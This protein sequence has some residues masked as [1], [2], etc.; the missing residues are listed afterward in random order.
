MFK[1]YLKTAIRNMKLL[2]RL[3][4]TISI[5]M[6]LFSSNVF[7]QSN[8]IENIENGLL[9]DVLIKGRASENMNIIDRMKHHNVPGVSIAVIDN[10]K[11][12]WAKA[13]GVLD[14]ESKNQVNTKTLFQAASISKP[15]ASIAALSLV[16]DG[17][18]KLEEN[19]NHKLTSWKVPDNEFTANHKVTLQGILNHSAGVTVHGFGGYASNEQVPSLLQVLNGEK[20]ANSDPI[21]VDIKPDSL[22]RYSGG[23]YTIM[24]QLLIDLEQKPFHELMEKKILA[25]LKMKNSTYEQPLP[26]KYWDNAARAH[27]TNGDMIAGNWHTYPEMAAAGLWTTPTDLAKFSIEMM[28]SKAGKSNKILSEEMT[29][30]MLTKVIGNNGLGFNLGGKGENFY[31]S[32]GGS[33]EG[34]KCN[35]IAIPGTGQGAVIMTNGDGGGNLASEII[36]AISKEYG[37]EIYKAKEKS[38]VVIDEK[39]YGQYEGKYELMPDFIVQVN[40]GD[41]RL[42]LEIPGEGVSEYYPISENKFFALDGGPTI[43]FIKNEQGEVIEIHTVLGEQEMIGKKIK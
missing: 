2:I 40:K 7:G 15:V 6:L 11:I 18:I 10:F 26:Q 16:Q 9:N 23:G 3:G 42:L 12:A 28:L 13:Y 33:N 21:R 20:P 31:F 19:I 25:P 36:R 39:L 37:W 41:K 22:S 4:L 29:N 5:S 1:N 24:Q 17:K 35:L 38:V 43:W 8:K 14:N 32:H 30:K 27:R 34:Y